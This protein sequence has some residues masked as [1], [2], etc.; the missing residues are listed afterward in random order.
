MSDIITFEILNNN[1]YILTNCIGVIVGM[2]V[3]TLIINKGENIEI[4]EIHFSLMILF[5]KFQNC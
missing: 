1:A 4:Y 2:I 3:T 5:L